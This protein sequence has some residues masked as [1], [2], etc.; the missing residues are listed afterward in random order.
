MKKVVKSEI[1]LQAM[2]IFDCDKEKPMTIFDCH[3]EQA[4][5]V[6]IKKNSCQTLGPASKRVLPD[7]QDCHGLFLITVKDCHYI[8]IPISHIRLIIT[9]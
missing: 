9:S 5:R 4:I 2:T 3:K 6:E 7:L 8:I 1:D